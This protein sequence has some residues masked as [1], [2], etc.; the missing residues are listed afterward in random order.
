MLILKAAIAAC[1]AAQVP[2]WAGE[3]SIRL[4]WDEARTVIAHIEPRSKVRTWTGTG[5]RTRVN[6]WLDRITD[7]GM[8]IRTRGGPVTVERARVHSIKVF[9]AKTHNMRNRKGMAIWIAPVAVGSYW[10]TLAAVWLTTGSDTIG[11]DKVVP[12]ALAAFAGP[13]T[14]WRLARRADRGSIR[15]VLD[16]GGKGKE[17]KT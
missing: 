16:H 7:T 8:T 3:I 9:P 2:V 4:K 6:G 17:P 12:P 11:A 10:L 5:G 13:W 14:A 1:L 15:I